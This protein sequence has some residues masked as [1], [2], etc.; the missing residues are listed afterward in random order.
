MKKVTIK[1]E[2][3]VCL[4]PTRE[5]YNELSDNLWWNNNDLKRFN[6]DYLTQIKVIS[7]MKNIDFYQAKKFLDK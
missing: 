1:K 6:I 4:I 7:T 3:K 2:V 5:E